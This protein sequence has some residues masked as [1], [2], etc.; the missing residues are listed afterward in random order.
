MEDLIAPSME[1]GAHLKERQTEKIKVCFLFPNLLVFLH[2]LSF[3]PR[4]QTAFKTLE[5]TPKFANFAEE[6]TTTISR[7]EL[8]F[9]LPPAVFKLKI[10][11]KVLFLP[12]VISP[13]RMKTENLINKTLTY[14]F[15]IA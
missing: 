2:L 1:T 12:F 4:F 15:T 8:Y 6:P 13:Q 10:L 7:S 5:I 9:L 3:F 11:S 14:L